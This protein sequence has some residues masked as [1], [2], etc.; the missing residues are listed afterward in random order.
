MGAAMPGVYAQPRASYIS[1]AATRTVRRAGDVAAGI[2][3]HEAFDGMV[4]LDDA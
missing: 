2:V 3:H 4:L 1:A